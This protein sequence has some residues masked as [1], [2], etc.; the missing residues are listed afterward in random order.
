MKESQKR[1]GKQ[2]FTM[3]SVANFFNSKRDLKE[4]IDKIHRITDE[5]IVAA[6]T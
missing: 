4:H 3:Q 5:K 6:I 2:N 1:D